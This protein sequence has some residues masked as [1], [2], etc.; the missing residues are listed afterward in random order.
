[1]PGQ[2]MKVVDEIAKVKTQEKELLYPRQGQVMKNQAQDV[3]VKPIVI[4]SM[5]IV[6]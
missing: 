5:E 2:G 3:P 6:E 4:E 1:M